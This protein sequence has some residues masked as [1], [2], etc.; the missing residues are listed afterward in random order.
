M[1]VVFLVNVFI[2]AIT[3]A[4]HYEFLHRMTLAMPRVR[5]Q[6]LRN[7]V[8]ASV[9]TI[10]TRVWASGPVNEVFFRCQKKKIQSIL[11]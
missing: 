11:P 9:S 7:S 3:V 1:I 5:S 8:A 10:A 2:I 4:I 6:R